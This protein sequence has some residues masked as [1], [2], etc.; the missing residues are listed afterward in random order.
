MMYVILRIFSR[1]SVSMAN[2]FEAGDN[3]FENNDNFIE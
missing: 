1:I 3:G 2:H